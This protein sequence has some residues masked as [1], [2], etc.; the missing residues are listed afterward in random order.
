M[1]GYDRTGPDG[2]G[3]KTGRGLGP[4]GDGSQRGR[5]LGLGRRRFYGS[6]MEQMIREVVKDELNKS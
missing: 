1:P 6:S 2:Q 4:C 5:G 3:Q